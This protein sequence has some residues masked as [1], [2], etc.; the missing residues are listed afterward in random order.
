MSELR[1][2]FKEAMW[3]IFL[4][5]LLWFCSGAIIVVWALYT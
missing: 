2:G 3:A 5:W 1:Q 4:G